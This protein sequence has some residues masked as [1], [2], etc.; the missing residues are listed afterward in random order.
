Q[1]FLLM[2]KLSTTQ[3]AAIRNKEVIQNLAIEELKRYKEVEYR[4]Q[5]PRKTIPQR[6]KCPLFQRSQKHAK[7]NKYMTKRAS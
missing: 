3:K 1:T 7:K 2:L 5:R 4:R 6:L